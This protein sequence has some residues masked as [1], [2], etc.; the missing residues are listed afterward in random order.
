MTPFET[1]PPDNATLLREAFRS[2]LSL[3]PE[4]EPHL[5]GALKHTLAHPGSLVRARLVYEMAQA[6]SLPKE[7]ARCL[8]VGIEYF[9]TASLLFDDLP[10]MDDAT[11][12]R[13]VPCVHQTHGEAA[14][15]LAALGL[16]NRAYALVWRGLAGLPT[17][18]Q[19]LAGDYVEHCLGVQGVLNGQSEDLHYGSLPE[20]RRSPGKVAVGKT[21]SLIKLSLVLPALA[22]G[23]D[24]DEIR[25]L[26]RLAAFWGLSYQIL[27][28]LK[29]IFLHADQTG[30]TGARDK[31]LNRPNSALAIG[32]EGSIHRL[33][34]LMRLGDRALRRLAA[35]VSTLSYLAEIRAR[36]R[37]EILAIR[38]ARLAHS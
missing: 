21:V 26:E 32:A 30:K 8:A 33:E 13:G 4:T 28:D 24:P 23:A 20:S 34:R 35:R 1:A 7:R 11:A 27:D 15:I 12:R 14:A 16:V 5:E 29:D 25:Q 18:R 36:F 19:V 9:H 22:A 17:E 38:S 3:P 2:G 31:S 6:Y 10:C 37:E